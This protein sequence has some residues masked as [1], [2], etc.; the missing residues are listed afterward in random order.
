MLSLSFYLYLS[1]ARFLCSDSRPRDPWSLRLLTPL[2]ES[3]AKPCGEQSR[4]LRL[5]LLLRRRRRLH[6][7][8]HQLISIRSLPGAPAA[9]SCSL[10]DESLPRCVLL[11]L[12]LTLPDQQELPSPLLLLLLRLILLSLP[13]PPPPNRPS[14]RPPRA[15][16]SSSS[17]LGSWARTWACCGRPGTLG[18]TSWARQTPRPRTTS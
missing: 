8:R 17:G 14:P 10:E 18:P 15:T 6:R 4:L 16:T 2:R 9:P 7:R 1:L 5:F 11:C 12:L 13:L 3:A